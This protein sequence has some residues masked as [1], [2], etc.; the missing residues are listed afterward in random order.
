MKVKKEIL[1]RF[2]SDQFSM[3]DY[4]TVKNYFT[5]K[6]YTTELDEHLQEDWNQKS[7]NQKANLNH[8]LLN[9]HHKIMPAVPKQTNTKTGWVY[10]FN[11][12]A[13]VLFIP[14]LITI[15][16]FSYNALTTEET[17]DSWVEVHSPAGARTQFQLPDGS[18]G[19]LNSNSSI[20]YEASFKQK[21][22]VETKGEVWL[23]VEHNPEKPFVVKTNHFNVKVLGT[24]FNVVSYSEEQD[25]HVILQ[26]G[27]VQV[28]GRNNRVLKELRPND[29]FHLNKSTRKY[30]VN[31]IDA[32]TYTSW[33]D[34]LL[35]FKNVPLGQVFQ[36]VGRKYNAEIVVHNEA[37]K[38]TIF[39]ATFEDETLEEVFRLLSGVINIK[40]QIHERTL[41]VDGMY[42]KIKVEVW[43]K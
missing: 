34:G 32:R 21:R 1:E 36:R 13:A 6:E 24:K 7:T 29:Q 3:K 30:A 37:L 25:A 11:R 17:T 26:E 28:L 9:I 43:E 41:G 5:D 20:K 31:S 39:R 14:A 35:I 40:Y 19:W 16:L 27:R 38:E 4:H 15:A 10:W 2:T 42:N 23:D 12:I 33:K 22:D 8:L 18:K